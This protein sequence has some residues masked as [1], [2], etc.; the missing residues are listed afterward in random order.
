MRHFPALQAPIGPPFGPYWAL[1]PPFLSP[2]GGPGIRQL[3]FRL[4][5]FLQLGNQTPKFTSKVHETLLINKII[6][7]ACKFLLNLG[8][9]F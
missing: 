8:I 9:I 1:G 3:S 4:E 7:I 5:P 2:E 6:K